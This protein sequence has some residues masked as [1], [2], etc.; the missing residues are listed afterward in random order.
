MVNFFFNLVEVITKWYIVINFT[1]VPPSSERTIH[2]TNSPQLL[3]IL[4]KLILWSFSINLM[5]SKHKV[6]CQQIFYAIFNVQKVE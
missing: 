3:L 5:L 6:I 1:R 4:V 2:S